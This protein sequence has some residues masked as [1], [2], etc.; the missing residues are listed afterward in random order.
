MGYLVM[1]ETILV[2]ITEWRTALLASDGQRPE[3]KLVRMHRT[4]SH[5]KEFQPQMSIVLKLRNSDLEPG[6]FPDC[7][8]SSYKAHCF[9]Y[10]KISSVLFI[11]QI[12]NTVCIVQD[13]NCEIKALKVITCFCGAKV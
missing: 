1:S 11:L 8:A 2:V 10:S 3:M 7:L 9:L 12:K 5:N 6:F 13:S 4:F